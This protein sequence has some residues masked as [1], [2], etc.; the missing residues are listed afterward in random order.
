MLG[1]VNATDPATGRSFDENK[2]LVDDI[3]WL[4]EADRR[5][6]FEDNVRQAYPRLSVLAART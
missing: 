3:A 6:I 5:K 2:R 1:G 4:T